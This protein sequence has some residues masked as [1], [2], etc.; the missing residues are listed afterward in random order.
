MQSCVLISPA[1]G[2]LRRTDGVVSAHAAFGPYDIIALV[3]TQASSWA[4]AR[5]RAISPGEAIPACF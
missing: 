5:P 3:E 4:I 2:V 1:L